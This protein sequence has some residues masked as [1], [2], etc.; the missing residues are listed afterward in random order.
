MSDALISLV[1]VIGG[2]IIHFTGMYWIDP[3]LS[4]WWP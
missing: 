2:V 4:I 1:L 3:A